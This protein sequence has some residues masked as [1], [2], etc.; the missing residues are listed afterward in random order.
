MRASLVNP[1]STD[2]TDNSEL[3]ADENF[4]RF[5]SLDKA[6]E[7]LRKTASLAR[8]HIDI[9]SARCFDKLY[10]NTDLI[11]VISIVARRH[12]S[13]RIRILIKDSTNLGSYHPLVALAQRLSSKI[14]IKTVQA[15]IEA[16]TSTYLISD[17]QH[18]L[19][20]SDEENAVGYVR[21]SAPAESSQLLTDFTHYWALYSYI[22]TNLRRL[23]L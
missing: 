1:I 19:R 20:F 2:K 9:L 22:D 12:A 4:V 7:E 23:T 21:H 10:A 15:D 5:D 14:T 11:D 18:L 13:A 3:K 8:R 16:P 17:E 6:S